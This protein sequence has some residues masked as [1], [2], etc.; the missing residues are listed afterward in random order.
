LAQL[1]AEVRASGAP[2]R[3]AKR[4]YQVRPRGQVRGVIVS[5]LKANGTMRAKEIHR[6][7]ERELGETV[8]WSSVANCLRENLEGD[9]ALFRKVG[10]GR[11]QLA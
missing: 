5:L 11:Y 6:A 9:D 2:I 7:V 10:H 3:R 4:E 8:P 1:M